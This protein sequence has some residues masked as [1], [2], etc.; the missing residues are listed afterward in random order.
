M[1]FYIHFLWQ[2]SRIVISTHD[3]YEKWICKKEIIEKIKKIINLFWERTIGK[4][5]IYI[6]KC[7]C[8]NI[9]IIISFYFFE[10]WDQKKSTSCI[11]SVLCEYLIK[12]Q[13]KCILRY[14]ISWP[15]INLSSILI[16]LF[17][18]YFIYIF[19]FV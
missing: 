4:I 18:Y 1:N 9:N 16:L 12:I 17:L 10:F 11:F 13:C 5:Y 14:R 8:S 3:I 15:I 6:Y 19:N 2:S 7:K